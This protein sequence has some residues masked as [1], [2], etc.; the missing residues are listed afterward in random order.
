MPDKYKL[1]DVS[2]IAIDAQDNAYVLHRPR[3]L[4]PED[5][6]RAAPPVMV[7]DRDGNFLTSWG[8]GQFVQPHAIRFEADGNLW[9]TDGHA[10]QFMKFSPDGKL[11]QTIGERGRR[12]DTGVPADDL[13]STAWSWSRD[14]R[15]SVAAKGCPLGATT[16]S[17]P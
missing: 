15:V 1:G 7:F 14:R 6:A 8:A 3:T 4:K 13:S 11:L 5:A 9:L 10:M 17:A 16:S 12:S 2:S